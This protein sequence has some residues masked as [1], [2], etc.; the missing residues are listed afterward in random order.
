MKLSVPAMLAAITALAS[1]QLPLLQAPSPTT[2]SIAWGP[3]VNGLRLGAEFGPDPFKPTLRIL[4]QNV[5]AIA[6]DVLVGGETGR[7]P[8]YDMKFMATAPDGRDREGLHVSAFSAIAGLV[9][10]LPVRLNAGETHELLFPLSE[11]IYTSPTTVRLDAL[12]KQGYTVRVRFEA[13]R[14]CG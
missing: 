11:I 13:N 14:G 6:Q 12:V 1:G 10:P 9:V 8:I 2:A 7:G 5:D 3:A 4:F